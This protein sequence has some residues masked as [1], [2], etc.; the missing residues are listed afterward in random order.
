MGA[1]CW[2][3]LFAG[4]V[5]LTTNERLTRRVMFRTMAGK[6]EPRTRPSRTLPGLMS[7]RRS[8]GVSS[9]GGVHGKLS[10]AVPSRDG[11]I[12]EGG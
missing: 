1:F 10:S 11:V 9:H 2:R 3:P 6:R 4:A 5:Q 12:I 7:S 8:Q